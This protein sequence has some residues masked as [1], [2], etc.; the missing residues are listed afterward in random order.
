M[1]KNTLLYIFL[2]GEVMKNQK[3]LI[4]KCIKNIIGIWGGIY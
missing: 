1:Y 3:N 2:W 4:S